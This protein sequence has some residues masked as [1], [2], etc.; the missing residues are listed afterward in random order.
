MWGFG[1]FCTLQKGLHIYA[2]PPGLGLRE[3]R[4]WLVYKKSWCICQWAKYIA[5]SIYTTTHAFQQNLNHLLGLLRGGN[6]F[7][8]SL[9]IYIYG[10]CCS[11]TA[12]SLRLHCAARTAQARCRRGLLLL[13]RCVAFEQLSCCSA[14]WLFFS[15]QAMNGA[16]LSSC[17]TLVFF[18]GP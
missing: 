2:P 4:K 16:R 14:E 15:A 8:T 5:I 1:L 18:C 12:T 17:R 7:M 3:I 6:F 11:S 13:L 10:W 9:S